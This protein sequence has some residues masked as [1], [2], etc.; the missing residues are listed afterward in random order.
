MGAGLIALALRRH[1]VQKTVGVNRWLSAV[2]FRGRQ[3]FELH[4][5]WYADT[6]G[7]PLDVRAAK[8]IDLRLKFFGL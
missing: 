7:L 5:L 2:W 6:K 1:W 8:Q 3:V 4:H